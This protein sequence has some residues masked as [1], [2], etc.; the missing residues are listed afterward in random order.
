M[1]AYTFS[2]RTLELGARISS[3]SRPAW[4]KMSSIIARAI[5]RN[6]VSRIK[7]KI[8]QQNKI[9]HTYEHTHTN[10]HTHTKQTPNA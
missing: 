10:T 9:K 2:S 6:P 4:S 3:S 8:R 7:T 5:Q 1:V